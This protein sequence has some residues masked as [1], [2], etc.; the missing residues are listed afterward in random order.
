MAK[1]QMT[2]MKYLGSWRNPLSLPCRLAK[3]PALREARAGLLHYLVCRDIIPFG[4]LPAG[5]G[6]ADEIE[7]RGC[8]EGFQTGLILRWK[9]CGGRDCLVL[10]SLPPTL[11]PAICRCCAMNPSPART[12]RIHE[13]IS[14]ILGLLPGLPVS[15]PV[16]RSTKI[17]AMSENGLYYCVF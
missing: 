13:G 16:P 8:K 1:G 6:L 4:R 17:C 12:G 9:A 5:L 7:S 10:R 15:V 11:S 3:N 2:E 14:L